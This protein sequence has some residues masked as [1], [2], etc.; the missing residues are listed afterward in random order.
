MSGLRRLTAEER[1]A[2]LEDARWMAETGECLDGAARRLGLLPE[3]LAK[4]LD[5]NNASDTAAL[6]RQRNYHQRGSAA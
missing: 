5:N 6:L 1:D 4:F 2:R 3:S